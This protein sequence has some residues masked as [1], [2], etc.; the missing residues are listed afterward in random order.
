VSFFKSKVTHTLLG[1]HVVKNTCSGIPF[2]LKRVKKKR[3]NMKL[4]VKLLFSFWW[5]S[6][7]FLIYI[8]MNFVYR[9]AGHVT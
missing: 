3:T 6:T 8:P 7:G 2:S 5:V 9:V 4:S 1:I